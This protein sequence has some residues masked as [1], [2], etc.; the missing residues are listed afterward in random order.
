MSP[1]AS[2]VERPPS[3]TCVS[4][5]PLGFRARSGRSMKPLTGETLP[6]E[7]QG[8]ERLLAVRAVGADDHDHG[9]G[10]G[11]SC[12]LCVGRLD[13][14][15]AE[16]ASDRARL[17]AVA[18]LVE[19]HRLGTLLLAGRRHVAEPEAGSRDLLPEAR[20]ETRDLRGVE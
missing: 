10:A 17:P 12:A 6:A 9:R 3:I 15:D 7:D 16:P 5:C 4:P 18:R 20:R 13:L 19:D 14:R 8:A 2:A 11:E 1:S